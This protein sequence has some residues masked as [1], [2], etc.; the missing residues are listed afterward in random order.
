[1]C[2]RNQKLTQKEEALAHKLIAIQAVSWLCFQDKIREAQK[3]LE[4]ITDLRL[5]STEPDERAEL[6]RIETLAQNSISEFRAKNAQIKSIVGEFVDLESIDPEARLLWF[7]NLPRPPYPL[8]LLESFRWFCGKE[9][10][11]NIEAIIADLGG[12]LWEVRSNLT[13]G[14]IAR[15]L[16]CIRGSNMILLHSFIKKTQKNSATDLNTARKRM[17]QVR[18]GES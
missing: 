14:K 15:V 8:R 18:E 7:G 6:E 3:L 17:A 5:K 2:P 9:N 10:R 1:M 12:G 4:Q 11:A 13:H 16:F